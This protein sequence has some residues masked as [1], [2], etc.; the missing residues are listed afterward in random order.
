MAKITIAGEAI[1]VTSAVKLEDYRKVAKYRP[2]ALTLLG[3]EDGKE[4]IFRAGVSNGGAGTIGKYG[5]EFATATHDE[6]KLASIT[7]VYTGE[8]GNDIKET[9]ADEI[10]PA[11]MLLNKLEA[12]LPDVLAEIDAEKAQILENITVAQ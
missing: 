7:L 10:G 3:G 2:K 5:A 1:V 8:A 12:T 4:P 9:V 6:Q 11:V